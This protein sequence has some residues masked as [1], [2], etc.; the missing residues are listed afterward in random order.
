MDIL[1]ATKSLFSK[2]KSE[3][4]TKE[5]VQKTPENIDMTINEIVN[6]LEN[7]NKEIQEIPKKSVAHNMV[8]NDFE[9]QLTKVYDFLAVNPEGTN[10]QELNKQI[11]A[12]NEL[13]ELTGAKIKFGKGRI[14]T[15]KNLMINI[16]A[17]SIKTEP[18]KVE[19]TKVEPTKVEPT[20]V[21]PTKVEPTKV[22]PTKVEPAKVE[23]AKVEPAKVEPA[24]VEPAKIKEI[25]GSSSHSVYS[26]A[27]KRES[28]VQKVIPNN[29]VE[30][31][32]TSSN[33]TSILSLVEKGL[34][35]LIA[36][37]TS[38]FA[39]KVDNIKHFISQVERSLDQKLDRNVKATID[40]STK[41]HNELQNVSKSIPKD[42]LKK[43]DF[44][45]ELGQQ[46]KKLDSLKD[47]SE[48]LE[49][50]PANYKSI[51]SELAS[52]NDKLDN[53]STSSVKKS[54]VKVPKHEKAVADLATYMR[55]GVEQLEN[56]SRLYVETIAGIESIEIERAQ[57]T[58][59]LSK[60][61]DEGI[62]EGTQR[63]E[64]LL[65]KKIAEQFPTEFEEIKSIFSSVIS[66]EYAVG[67]AVEVTN[68][69]K[70]GLMP[71]FSTELELGE[72]QVISSDI[73]IAGDIVVKARVEKVAQSTKEG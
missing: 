10:D 63:G 28:M 12:S 68:E 17:K 6:N 52:I 67:Q 27:P 1:K 18:T 33:L 2:N 39:N 60:S 49:S 40:A 45:F 51:K 64:G 53:V 9:Y 55:D 44:S 25:G 7:L 56:M 38:E 57:H 14:K 36:K 26:T 5:P 21:E 41:L 66:F 42:I 23:P 61:K 37:S 15:L 73:L 24:K 69:N 3:D 19:P 20:K 31:T 35:S 50:L 8:A 34:K 16:K 65:A 71:Y 58:E 54:S 72:Y 13:I 22:E 59:Q 30:L 4:K 47:V 29:K 46:F 48:D 32:D 70:N 11:I 62:K 43:E